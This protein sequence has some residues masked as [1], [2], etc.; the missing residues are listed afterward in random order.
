MSIK[1]MSLVWEGFRASGSEMLAMLALADWCNDEGGSLHP[2]MRAVAEKI[3]V[4]EKQ[5]RRILHVFED[6]GYLK[7]IGNA[8]GGAPGTT[9][10]YQLNVAKLKALADEPAMRRST[11]REVS[12][13]PDAAPPPRAHC[14]RQCPPSSRPRR[15][16]RSHLCA[17]VTSPADV[18]PP[19]DVTPHA[20]V[21]ASA[22][23]TPPTHGRR[24]LPPV[25][26]EGSHGCPE[27]APTG[28]SQTTSEPPVNR[29]LTVRVTAP[30]A[31]PEL[32][33]AGATAPAPQEA[34]V[35]ETR[36]QSACR[37][38]W[39]AY[40]EAYSDR[41]GTPPVRNQKVSSQVKQFVQRI[42]Y[43]ESPLVAAW[44]VRHPGGYYV[45]RMHDFG[46]LLS[47]AEKLRTEWA[48]RR[49]MT[50]GRARQSDRAGT[51]MAALAEVLA[52]QGLS[53]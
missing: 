11:S 40:R 35:G 31:Q 15:S 43:A 32:L 26:G 20:D 42:G 53:L 14:A 16:G 39:A 21:I 5:A 12:P 33:L 10:Q 46:C 30:S 17:D 1:V 52:K 41:Y 6:A 8:N 34:S 37:V 24:G 25:G 48:T 36:L 38:T 3:R 18:T 29:H 49:F 4:S 47:D 23:G 28:G 44:F 19:T 22:D 13:P 9:K 51:T 27:T 2:S 50:S 45:G 7:V